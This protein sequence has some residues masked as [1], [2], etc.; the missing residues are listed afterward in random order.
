MTEQ[1]AE[2]PKQRRRIVK[3]LLVGVVGFVL[4]IQ[5]A[6]WFSRRPVDSRFVGTWIVKQVVPESQP[7]DG[8]GTGNMGG[9]IRRN[10]PL[11]WRL[12]DNGEGT[13]TPGLYGITSGQPFFWRVKADKLFFELEPSLIERIDRALTIFSGGRGRPDKVQVAV[14]RITEVSADEIVL[15]GGTV[16]LRPVEHHLRRSE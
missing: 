5:L 10:E 15:S 16:G 13:I 1:L 9:S 8:M 14:Y 3:W 2:R 4:L 7:R 12:E 6:P 11:V